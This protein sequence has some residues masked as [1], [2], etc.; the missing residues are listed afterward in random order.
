MVDMVLPWGWR[1]RLFNLHPSGW[2]SG[3]GREVGTTV[4]FRLDALPD[5]ILGRLVGG[6][7]GDVVEGPSGGELSLSDNTQLILA[8]CEA[9]A[10]SG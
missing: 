5:S 7:I 3:R 1:P 4:E 8:T 6:A 10:D 9:I 2:S